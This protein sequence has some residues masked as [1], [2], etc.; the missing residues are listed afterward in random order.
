MDAWYKCPSVA[1]IVQALQEC[2][3]VRGREEVVAQ[4]REFAL[5]YDAGLVMEEYWKP[6]LEQLERPKVVPPLNRAQRRA[7]AKVAA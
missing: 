2:Y 6:A 1:G 3:A 7:K 5:R 4:A